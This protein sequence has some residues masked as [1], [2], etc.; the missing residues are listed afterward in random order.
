MI[1]NTETLRSSFTVDGQRLFLIYDE[2]KKLYR[3]ATR[4]AWLVSFDNVRD[5]CDAFDSIEF[6][7][8]D[9][10]KAA[11]IVKNEMVRTSRN[12]FSYL[13]NAMARV[14]WL[15]SCVERR[16]Q[17]LR[18]VYCGSKGSVIKWV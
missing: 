11:K 8:G 7:E 16:L 9:L 15:I 2:S 6:M 13:N 17:G 14:N 12:N 1:K 10:R 4:W 3:V 18:P 5:A